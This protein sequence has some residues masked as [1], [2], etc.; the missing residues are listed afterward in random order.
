MAKPYL[1]NLKTIVEQACRS[2]DRTGSIRC[3]HFFGGA[4]AYVDGRIFMTLSPVGLALKL[5]EED[6]ATLFRLG[7]KPLKYFPNAPVKKGYA[8]LPIEH[9]EDFGALR[10]IIARSIA[11]VRMR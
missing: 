2:S 9:N 10:D 4:A 3:K 7:A 5:S 6:R 11:F 8:L 1:S